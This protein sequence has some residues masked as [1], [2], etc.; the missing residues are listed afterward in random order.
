MVSRERVVR[1]RMEAGS[2][3]DRRQSSKEG[4]RCWSGS[5]QLQHWVPVG[6]KW[7]VLG[8]GEGNQRSLHLGLDKHIMGFFPAVAEVKGK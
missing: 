7:E 2:L 1:G 5:V 4:L 6:L 3:G 8:E